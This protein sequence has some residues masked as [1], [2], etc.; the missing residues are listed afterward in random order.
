MYDPT[1][2]RWLSEDPIGFEAGDANLNRYVGNAATLFTD[3]DGLQSRWRLDL[4]DHGGPH[5]QIGDQRWRATDFSPMKHNGKIPP[6]LT[7]RQMEEL[8]CQGIWD[9]ILKNVPD[10]NI[11]RVLA[12]EIAEEVAREAR[13][14]GLKNINR[15]VGKEIAEQVLRRTP[16]GLII[17]LLSADEVMA[18]VNYRGVAFAACNQVIPA[19]LIEDIVADSQE[20]FR[21]WQAEQL[22]GHINKK[23]RRWG[24]NPDGTLAD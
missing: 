19:S 6:P 13:R 15:R 10:N 7:I 3:P 11:D 5:I 18:D 9:R 1:V 21:Q 4:H 2:G 24:I 20:R 8:R 14:R 12:E 17:I 22:E 23:W 16:V